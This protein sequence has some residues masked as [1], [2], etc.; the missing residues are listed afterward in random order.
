MR[1]LHRVIA[2]A[3]D[4]GL[5]LG[6][7]TL[8][9]RMRRGR[10]RSPYVFVHKVGGTLSGLASAAKAWCCKSSGGNSTTEFSAL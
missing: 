6:S 1:V 10:Q 3:T 5:W 9:K 8:L 4:V 2:H 7:A